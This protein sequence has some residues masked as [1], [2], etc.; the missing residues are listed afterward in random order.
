MSQS[1]RGRIVEKVP[2]VSLCFICLVDCGLEEL[3]NIN[4]LVYEKA[5][6]QICPFSMYQ[7]APTLTSN[8]MSSLNLRSSKRR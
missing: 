2:F 4:E 5:V 6:H 8:L 3:L 7:I 1:C